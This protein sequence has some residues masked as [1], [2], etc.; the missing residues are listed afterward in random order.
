MHQYH[1]S[2]TYNSHINFDMLIRELGLLK[3][4]ADSSTIV[5]EGKRDAETLRSLGIDAEFYFISSNRGT[6]RELA[7]K[8]TE[9]EKEVIIL[10][11][12]DSKGQQLAG[13]LILALHQT[14][15]KVKVNTNVRKNLMRAF[16]G[17]KIGEIEDLKSLIEKIQGD[18]NGK[19][20][21]SSDKIHYK[22]KAHSNRRS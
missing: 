8:L 16:N 6:I 7:E 10:T 15:K 14:G 12:F 18:I 11:D 5:V 22:S 17:R 2:Q 13:K 3:E 1:S 21:N 20:W 4:L 19:N 9:Q